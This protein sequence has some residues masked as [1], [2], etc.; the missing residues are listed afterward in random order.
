MRLGSPGNTFN[1]TNEVSW[2]VYKDEILPLK[3][4]GYFNFWYELFNFYML[5]VGMLLV[6]Y[7]IVSG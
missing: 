4:L 5:R 3:K 7:G 6:E 1:V 2:R